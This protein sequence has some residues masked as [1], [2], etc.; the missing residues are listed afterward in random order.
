[1][2]INGKNQFTGKKTLSRFLADLHAAESH[3]LW[4]GIALSA[5]LG[6]INGIGVVLLIPLLQVSGLGTVN[7]RVGDAVHG[8]FEWCGVAPTVT[9][10]LVVFLCVTLSQAALF[11]WQSQLQVRVQQGF[12]ATLRNRLFHS[13]GRAPWS[14]F[15]NLKRSDVVHILTTET[16][17]VSVGTMHVMR[18]LSNSLVTAVYFA[19]A[20]A[21]SPLVTCLAVV[22]AGL[23]WPIN[24]RFSKR[25]KQSGNNFTSN[26]RAYHNAIEE[27][28][29]GMKEVRCLGL[30]DQHCR[31]FESLTST[32]VKTRLAFQSALTRTD[33]ANKATAVMSLVAIAYVSLA[34]FELGVS[35]LLI[36]VYVF[37][38]VFPLVGQIHQ[39][40]QN[41]VHMLPAYESHQEFLTRLDESRIVS[42]ES[43][44]RP[45]RLE[46]RI[47][48]EQLCFRYDSAK[49][50]WLFRDLSLTIPANRTTAIVGASGAGKSTLIDLL[51][52]LLQPESG[53]VY[54]DDLRLQEHHLQSWQSGIGYVSQETF[55][56]HDTLRANLLWANAHASDEDIQRAI[57]LAAADFVWK[58]PAGLD[59]VIGDRGIRLSGGERQRIAIARAIIRRPHVLIL[60]EATSGLDPRTQSRIHDS[61]DGLQ[62]ETT[63]IRIVHRPST[64][65]N[66]SNI[67][68]L[69]HGQIMQFGSYQQLVEI[70]D[71]AFVR[72]MQSEISGLAN[73]HDLSHAA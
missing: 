42:Q 47:H 10:M 11:C 17:R 6:L 52:G 20:C 61:L 34:V 57:R 51:I 13:I 26:A 16:D 73:G 3:S 15:L 18:L 71:G 72:L 50:E 53:C 8:L 27:N 65:I 12:T 19:A 37:S 25:S 38:R 44:E 49:D 35:M 54:V 56:F 66:A 14:L 41:V 24:S 32:L 60:D 2:A 63:I 23:T 9:S 1:M 30:Y 64:L 68:V 22:C 59:T 69:E 39:S 29:A 62:H 70:P 40:R 48:C 5:V 46:A 4:L 21:I 33:F 43:C 67:V 45:I 28:L 36:P 58:L 7:S 31:Q 55:L